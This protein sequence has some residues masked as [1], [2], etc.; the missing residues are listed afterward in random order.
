VTSPGSPPYADH[1]PDL[2]RAATSS[3]ASPR[4]LRRVPGGASRET[5]YART[6]AAGAERELIIRVEAAGAARPGA[7][8]LA[9]EAAVMQAAVHAGVTTPAILSYDETAIG[10]PAIVMPMVP[11][12]SRSTRIVRRAEFSRARQMLPQQMARELARVHA[13]DPAAV[14]F[15][16]RR[17][18]AGTVLRLLAD[19][20]AGMPGVYPTIQYVIAKLLDR[21]LPAREVVVCHGDVRVGNVLVSTQ[22]GLTAVLDWE[23][24]HIGDFLEDLT[25][26][27]VRQWRFGRDD[28]RLGGIA[29]PDEFYATYRGE[30][31]RSLD[32]E[33]L[34]YWEIVGNVKWALGC[35]SQARRHLDNIDRSIEYALLGRLACEPAFEALW[36]SRQLSDSR[37]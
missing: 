7:L 26:P 10:R 13:I 1:L 14:P 2:I 32:D 36:L 28:L 21:P 4:T 6:D 15:L 20:L 12:E 22:T 30:T 9:Q 11:G 24:A 3:H 37:T 35:L 27:V 17:D 31:G 23:L 25:W 34:L 33:S 19:E 8:T 5:W 18:S 16:P 29:P